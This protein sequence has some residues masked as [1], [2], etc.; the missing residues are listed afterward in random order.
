MVNDSFSQSP[1][2]TLSLDLH[3]SHLQL[4]LWAWLCISHSISLLCAVSPSVPIRGKDGWL[5]SENN[6][7]H[8]IA[9]APSLSLVKPNT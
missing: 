5:G 8:D 7:G 6:D 9:S 1:I 3:L 4:T 2:I